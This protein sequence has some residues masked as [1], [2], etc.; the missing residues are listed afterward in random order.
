MRAITLGT[1]GCFATPDRG[2]PALAIEIGHSWLLI[3]VGENT[4][5]SLAQYGIEAD[6][7]STIL[8]THYHADHTAGL[9]PLLFGL[10][11]LQKRAKPLL[12]AGPPN[13]ARFKQGLA[14]AFGE[15]IE[16]PGF[17]LVWRELQPP[18][19]LTPDVEGVKIN[20][21]EVEHS[22]H[23][24]CLGYRIEAV[25]KTM[26]VSGDTQACPALAELANGADLLIADAGYPDRSPVPGHLTPG[27]LAA[28]AAEAGVKKIALTHFADPSLAEQLAQD[29]HK[30][31]GGEVTAAYDGAVFKV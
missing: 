23:L 17:P 25:G 30:Q 12:I 28:L 11:A 9:A 31:F 3:D 19:E 15:C 16:R 7:I 2:A 8:I 1:G 5:R 10:Y 20:F 24:T 22:L 14:M 26:T 29:T 21:R 6:L 27:S 4:W 18:G 13:L